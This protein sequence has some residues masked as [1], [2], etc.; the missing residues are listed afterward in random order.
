MEKTL[1]ADL[2]GVRVHT[3]GDSADAAESLGARAFTVGSDVHFG[4]GEFAP[5]S[6]EGDRLLAHELTHVVQGHKSGVQ[7]KADAGHDG[8]AAHGDHEAGGHEV[9]EPGDASEKEADAMGDH[10]ADK[11]HGGGGEHAHDGGDQGAKGGEHGGGEHGGGKKAAPE[12]PK[13]GAAA[14]TVGRKIFRAEKPGAPPGSK[15]GP[16]AP[17]AKPG[18]AG[19]KDPKQAPGAGAQAPAGQ[20]AAAPDPKVQAAEKQA[21]DIATRLGGDPGT[22]LLLNL[23]L[24][25]ATLTKLVETYPD[26]AVIKNAAKLH[27]DKLEATKTKAAKLFQDLTA[28]MTELPVTGSSYAPLQAI[29]R[30][31]EAFRY[32]GSRFTRDLVELK[33]FEATFLKQDKAITTGH[34]DTCKQA[35]SII[36][37]A[38]LDA[39]GLVCIDHALALIEGWEG[40]L[41]GNATATANEQQIRTSAESQRT[42]IH[43]AMK[44]QQQQQQ[45]Q[46]Q[47]EQQKAHAPGGDAKGGPQTPGAAAAAHAGPAA[48][49]PT[50]APPTGAAAPKNQPAAPAAAPPAP[51]AAAAPPA[52]AP[53]PPTADA[54]AA[55]SKPQSPAPT[56]P[57]P[58]APAPAAAPTPASAA[59]PAPDAAGAASAAHGPEKPVESAP[60][61]PAQ[62]QPAAAPASNAAPAPAVNA[63]VAAPGQA[64]PA[65]QGAAPG[66]DPKAPSKKE[67]TPEELAVELAEKEVEVLAQ[68]LVS[69]VST[70]GGGLSAV[71][72]LATIGV[73]FQGGFLVAIGKQ[74][75]T[76]LTKVLAEQI[77]LQ[78]VELIKQL[79][80][81]SVEQLLADFED[82]GPADGL[83]KAEDRI[84]QLYID[85]QKAKARAAGK[86]DDIEAEHAQ[87]HVEEE[88]REKGE[89]AMTHV[90][91]HTV[92]SP[93]EVVEG[94]TE[95]FEILEHLGPEAIKAVLE[96]LP[97]IIGAGLIPGLGA[98]LSIK[99]AKHES[100]NLAKKMQARD[101]AKVALDAAR[102]KAAGAASG[103]AAG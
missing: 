56:P 55:T 18:P 41:V 8:D 81:A 68:N 64:P 52:A 12:K 72:A 50:G 21:T 57:A 73:H 102:A 84:Q 7:R 99:I 27:A 75:T 98:L 61:P 74:L 43:G 95:L 31:E 93:L 1:G 45:Q 49:P 35:E 96:S 59:A 101:E 33:T 9:S 83:M 39:D 17:G 37:S 54:S 4:R 15:P 5:G 91:K 19:A 89:E 48:T 90:A 69:K 6:R 23:D 60:A 20:Q 46:Q 100:K 10:A 14:P 40:K 58:P 70:F 28:K 76:I 79:D 47:A 94:G 22:G 26:N 85:S 82:G 65:P 67:K 66:A 30:N 32:G 88:K 62:A 11:L 44:Q 77:K 16:A 53:K 29:H 13:V 103:A 2:S 71:S 92:K 78:S 63:A 80:P 42:K 51:A 36:A 87:A 3:G 38:P 34:K 24:S 86:D 25:E 97:H